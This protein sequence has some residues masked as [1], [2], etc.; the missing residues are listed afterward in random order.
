MIVTQYHH[1]TDDEFIRLVWSKEDKSEI[2][3]EL[4]ARLIRKTN[5]STL[6]GE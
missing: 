2:E 6:Y 3:K 4:L 1:L 5:N